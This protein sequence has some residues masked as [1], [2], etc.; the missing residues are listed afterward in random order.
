MI[1]FNPTADNVDD[2]G[3][4]CGGEFVP[5]G[6]SVVDSEAGAATSCGRMLCPKDRVAAPRGLAS[7]LARTCRSKLRVDQLHCMLAHNFHS[8]GIYERPLG[9]SKVKFRTER[10]AAELRQPMI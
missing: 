3:T 10:D 6:D 2:V 8:T 9:L 5:F 7:V 4:L 1:D